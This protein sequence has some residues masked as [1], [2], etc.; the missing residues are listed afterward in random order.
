MTS[1]VSGAICARGPGNEAQGLINTPACK[2]FQQFQSED[3]AA[4]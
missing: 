2:G 1:D 4:T 3:A